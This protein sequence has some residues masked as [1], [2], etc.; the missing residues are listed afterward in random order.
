M[1]SPSRHFAFDWLAQIKRADIIL[2]IG[3][4]GRVT[5]LLGQLS[6]QAKMV[7]ESPPRRRSR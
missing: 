7:S 2:I 6:D 4:I 5:W 3:S 1:L